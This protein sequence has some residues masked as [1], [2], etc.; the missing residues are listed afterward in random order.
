MPTQTGALG[1]LAE[2]VERHHDAAARA[3]RDPGQSLDAVAWI[4]AHLAAVDRVLYPAVRRG[5]PNGRRVLRAQCSTD[6]RLLDAVWRLDRRLTGDGRNASLT[7]PAAL[8]SVQQ[9][10]DD[11]SAGE[12]RLLDAVADLDEATRR[13]VVTR[14]REMTER[15]PTRPHPLAPHA[16]GVATLAFRIDA[17]VDGVRDAL[18]ARHIPVPRRRRRPRA[19]GRWG[20]YAL[21]AANLY[22]ESDPARVQ[23]RRPSTPS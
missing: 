18:D 20:L 11:H 17:L 12:R 14:L 2:L 5:Q 10:L 9:H 1:E 3:L 21:G 23:R 4:S 7:L 22:P 6:R 15:A 13:G 16:P 19:P 8:A